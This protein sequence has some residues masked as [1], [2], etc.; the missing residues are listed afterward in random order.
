M[1][2]DRANIVCLYKILEKYSDEEHI[3]SMSDITG[4]F[5]Q[6]YGMKID[7]RAVYGAADTLIE[8]GYDISVYKENGKG[9][10]LRSRLFEPSEVRLMT[11]AVYSMHSIPQKQTADL[12]EKL[13][14][15]LS[16]HQRFGFKHLTSAD[17]DRKTDNRCVFY[18]ID[19]L[20]EAI[21]RQRRV[22]FDYYQYGL[23]KR[24][25]KRRNEPYVVSPYGMVCDNQNYYLVCIKDGKEGLSY[26]R[27]D[28]M[29]NIAI[30]DKKLA[31]A[32]SAVNLDS[33]RKLVYAF[34]GE[35]E[36][37]VLKCK[38]EAI[39]GIIDKFGKSLRIY[40]LDDRHFIAKFKAAPQGVI[41][42]TM[43]YLSQVEVIEPE[44]MRQK[45]IEFIKSNP[46][47]ITAESER[48]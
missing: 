13:Q 12:L 19:I 38:N 47:G 17:A 41:Y 4:Y 15:V 9:Y 40:K 8:L 1:L 36:Q 24:L 18:N 21:S 39:G 35:P 22:S 37:I 7:R 14:S 43:Q 45:A 11:D 27:I 2:G 31:V 32:R 42:W 33:V 16:I 20:D 34:S 28:L 30:T 5:M 44:H 46:Y 23:D 10:Y 48:S 3:L 6:D 25:V 29:Q 26:Y